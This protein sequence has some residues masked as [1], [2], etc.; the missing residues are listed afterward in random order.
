VTP[1]P[2]DLRGVVVGLNWLRR[3]GCGPPV[4]FL[5]GITLFHSLPD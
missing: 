5:F 4:F 2:L 3:R 1:A